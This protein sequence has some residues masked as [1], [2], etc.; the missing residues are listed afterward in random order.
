VRYHPLAVV[1][2]RGGD[3]PQYPPG[4]NL[5]VQLLPAAVLVLGSL[6]AAGN[7]LIAEKTDPETAAIHYPEDRCFRKAGNA[8]NP[9]LPKDQIASV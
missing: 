3:Y 6:Q 5:A 2:D 1:E 9:I 8:R 4:E 7:C